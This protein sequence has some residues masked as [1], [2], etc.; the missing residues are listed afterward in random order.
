M[1][2]KGTTILTHC[3]TQKRGPLQSATAPLSRSS[4]SDSLIIFI[5]VRRRDRQQ[6]QSKARAFFTRSRPGGL[7]C[8][9]ATQQA[10]GVTTLLLPV[11]AFPPFFTYPITVT[12]SVMDEQA[13]SESSFPGVQPAR[14]PCRLG[15]CGAVVWANHAWA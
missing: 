13:S 1:A 8:A 2:L 3:G 11:P 14:R 5:S 7:K 9:R 10:K 6:E 12:V 4:S 15:A